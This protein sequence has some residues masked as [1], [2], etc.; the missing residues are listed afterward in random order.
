MFQT[1]NPVDNNVLKTYNF[2]S[3]QNINIKLSEAK[4][5]SHQWKNF[6]FDEKIKCLMKFC[7]YMQESADIIAYSITEEMGKPITQ[8]YAE[9]NKSINLCKY[10]CKLKESIFTEVIYT[11]Y[12]I[13]C[14]RF[15]SIGAILGIMPWNYPIWQT[16]RS[17]IPNLIL[18]NVI[19]IKPSLN[20]TGCSLILEKIFL[21]TGFP[22]GTF[23]VLLID[24]N[25]IESV[26]AHPEIKGI[27][28]TGSPSVGSIIGSLSGKYIKKSVL[29]LGGN[30][31]F[32]VLK[33]V[34][35]IKKVAK[36]AT[37][38][39]LN[40][41]GQTCISAKRFIVDKIIID[42][43]IDAVIQEMKT[44]HRGNLY[45][46]STK[47]GYISRCDL[48]EKLY[49]QY[50]NIIINGGKI[51]LEITKDGNFFTP[52]LLRIEN[53]NC[54]VKKEE[55]FGPIGII[56]SF[57]KEE[58]IPDIV[59]D[60]PYGLGASIWTKNLEKA[61]EISKKIDTGMVFINE[62]VKSDP[63]FPFG[64]IKKSGY[65]RELSTLSIKEFSNWKTIIMK[66]L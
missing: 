47:I 63:R 37:E 66:E 58:M 41:T 56:S 16:I 32:V 17:T 43:F 5:A 4:N 39:R 31:A 14:V 55:I 21:K 59:N 1:I 46:E 35:D 65:G 18:G 38:S 33:D 19:L 64:G 48:S 36:L 27:T 49:Q 20:T 40:N 30:D 13:S 34:E 23:Q 24:I 52:S 62:V 50:K 11:E 57:Y 22:E 6:P 29:E 10:Y 51:C 26:I 28:F 25:Q 53:D 42:D 2:L 45:D 8:S 15:E 7:S 61:E 44:Y 3:N 9:V 12:K 54:I 60:T